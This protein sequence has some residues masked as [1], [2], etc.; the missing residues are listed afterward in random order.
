MCFFCSKEECNGPRTERQARKLLRRQLKAMARVIADLPAERL[1]TVHAAVRT[2][3]Q[4][5]QEPWPTPPQEWLQGEIVIT[6]KRKVEVR[7]RGWLFQPVT[8]P[9]DPE[10]SAAWAR[11]K[12]LFQEIEGGTNKIRQLLAKAKGLEQE[13]KA[14]STELETE[15]RRDHPF[16][17]KRILK[18]LRQGK[19]PG[20]R[21]PAESTHLLDEQNQIEELQAQAKAKMEEA[22]RMTRALE[23]EKSA[24]AANRKATEEALASKHPRLFQ[25]YQ[26]GKVHFLDD[27]AVVCLILELS[28][29]NETGEAEITNGSLPQLTAR[30][31]INDQG[32]FARYSATKLAVI[33]AELAVIIADMIKE[34]KKIQ[35]DSPKPTPTREVNGKLGDEI[36]TVPA[37]EGGCDPPRR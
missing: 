29:I 27:E 32:M 17:W 16:W 33:I 8:E 36:L 18:S 10:V 24:L 3:D 11:V 21:G 30:F 15:V 13:A 12:V 20:I 5:I 19:E 26:E 25:K 9:I 7:R 37:K 14:K 34:A 2:L 4:L 31:I 6:P 28:E 22:S 1:T 23:G 35:P